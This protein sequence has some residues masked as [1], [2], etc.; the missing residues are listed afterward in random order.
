MTAQ[1]TVAAQ[2]QTV[3][4]HI[5]ILHTE[6]VELHCW[7][8]GEHGW[9]TSKMF[10]EAPQTEEQQT[11]LIDALQEWK[12]KKFQ[13]IVG[14]TALLCNIHEYVA[15]CSPRARCCTLS[16]PQRAVAFSLAH[17]YTEHPAHLK[18]FGLQYGFIQSASTAFIF[19]VSQ[20]NR[21]LDQSGE[22]FCCLV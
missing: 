18:M 8:A 3:V 6:Y 1:N 16:A 5:D 12:S 15:Q 7:N 22:A 20:N 2:A 19:S 13:E 9:P 14:G 4:T 21:S 11:A 17:H 10:G